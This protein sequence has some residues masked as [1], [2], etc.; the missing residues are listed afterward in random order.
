GFRP[1]DLNRD[2]AVLAN[3]GD[4]P[5][6]VSGW[7]ICDLSTRCFR[8]PPG[9][10]VRPNRRIVVYTGYGTPDGASFFMNNDRRVW[11]ED[12]DE[13]TL[14]DEYGRLVLRHVY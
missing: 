1:G 6:D 8:F 12:G 13:A 4:A 2:F 11:N 9:T 10:S 14:Y 3:Q 7:R 5:V